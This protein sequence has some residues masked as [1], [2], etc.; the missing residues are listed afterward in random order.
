M[1][2]WLTMLCAG[3]LTFGMR[4]SLVWLLGR[5]EVPPGLRRALHFVPPAV[6]SA[7]ALPE[8]FIRDGQLALGLDN[9]RLLAGLAAVLVGLYSKNSLLTI[10]S[11]ML[12]LVLLQ[13]LS[14]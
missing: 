8:L 5:Y 9:T 10:L 6:L 7:I 1:N 3:L 11:G 14:S 13:I 12:V 2:I 4:F